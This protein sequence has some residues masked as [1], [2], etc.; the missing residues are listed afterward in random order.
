[1]NAK[2]SLIFFPLI[3]IQVLTVTLTAQ[4]AETGT[5]SM[6]SVTVSPEVLIPGIPLNLTF[7]IDY[8]NPEDV[9]V[10]APSF[11]ASVVMDRIVKYPAMIG[12][13][14]DVSRG[15]Q[16]RTVVEYRLIPNTGGHITLGSFSIQTPQSITDTGPFSLIIQNPV[17]EQRFVTQRLYWEGF[18]TGS[19]RQVTAGDRIT[20]IL[21]A[22]TWN[23]RQPPA[24][25]FMPDVPQGVILAAQSLSA[26]ERA[27]GIIIKLTFIPLVAGDFSLPARVIDYEDVRFEIPALNIYINNRN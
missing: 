3:I 18:Q 13:P 11:P 15:V 14:N 26:E 24:S 22:Q 2:L 6:V 17:M 7:I 21:R 23:S 10:I 5:G 20:L 16:L 9:T 27:Y 1:M 4:D 25:F 12:A 19:I 8:P